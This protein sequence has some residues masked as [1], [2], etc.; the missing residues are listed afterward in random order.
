[1]LF[2]L[3]YIFISHNY[4]DAQASEILTRI[5]AA[6]P[7]KLLII[8]RVIF[9]QLLTQASTAEAEQD[10]YKK[11]R[12]GGVQS[13]VAPTFYDLGMIALHGGRARL[14]PEWKALL[15]KTGFSISAVY[16]MR[17][18]TGQFVVDCVPVE[19]PK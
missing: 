18:S 2:S 11:L 1:V 13:Q 8:E 14:F 19:P 5:R 17:A 7:S 3:T 12:E 15:E 10:I 16:P 4:P 9:P 6:N